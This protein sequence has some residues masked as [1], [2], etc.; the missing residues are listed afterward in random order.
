[1]R[2]KSAGDQTAPRN[3]TPSG[4]KS[5]TRPSTASSA[6]FPRP[7]PTTTPAPSASSRVRATA[8]SPAPI[9]PQTTT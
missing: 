3:G 8:T 2:K 7:P 9:T 4:M 6:M 1:M 5:V